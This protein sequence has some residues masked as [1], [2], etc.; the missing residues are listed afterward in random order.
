MGSRKLFY[1]GVV[2][3]AIFLLFFV[4]T[5]VW[6]GRDAKSRC[7]EAKRE[8]GG[9]TSPAASQGRSDCVEA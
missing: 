7:Q 6:I 9:P 3:A 2:A 8:Y 5:C 4:I 1:V